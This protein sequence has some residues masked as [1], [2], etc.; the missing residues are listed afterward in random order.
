MQ[1]KKTTII[2]A[3]LSLL[4]ILSATKVN[5]GVTVNCSATKASPTCSVKFT[6]SRTDGSVITTANA[7]ET[8]GLWTTISGYNPSYHTAYYVCENSGDPVLKLLPGVANQTD[9]G[10]DWTFANAGKEKCYIVFFTMGTPP[11]SDWSNA[12]SSCQTEYVTVSGASTPTCTASFAPT[13]LTAPGSSNLTFSST[14][15]DKLSGSCTGPLPIPSVD[16]PSSYANYPFTFTATQTGTETC[17]FVP[18]NGTT[19]GTTCLASVAVSAGNN[20]PCECTNGPFSGGSSCTGGYCDGCYCVYNGSKINGL[21]GSANNQAVSSA[22]TSNL[23][24][25]GTASAVT[26]TGL[27]NWTCAGT[28]GGTTASCS[29]TKSGSGSNCGTAANSNYACSATETSGTLCVSGVTCYPNQGYPPTPCPTNIQLSGTQ[30]HWYCGTDQNCYANK[31][32]S[33]TNPAPTPSPSSDYKS[34]YQISGEPRGFKDRNLPSKA[35]NGSISIA[36]G[37]TA[38]M[39]AEYDVSLRK[40]KFFIPPGAGA[41]SNFFTTAMAYVSN[42]SSVFYA[43]RYGTPPKELTDFSD[44]YRSKLS[45]DPHSLAELMEKDCVGV[46]SVGYLEILQDSGAYADSTLGNWVYVDLYVRKGAYLSAFTNTYVNNIDSYTK[47]YNSAQWGA[48]GDPIVS[49]IIPIPALP[50]GPDCASKVCLGNSCYNGTTWIA[51]T[52][53]TDCATGSATAS[54]ASVKP[55][56]ID[57]QPVA[58]EISYLTWTSQNAKSMEVAC[59]GPTIIPRGAFFLNTAEWSTESGYKKPTTTTP[60]GYPGW[61]H[62]GAT[63]T[64]VCTFYPTNTKDSLPGTPFSA[65]IQVTGTPTCGNNI[66]EGTEECDYNPSAGAINYVPC[67]AG[68]ACKECKC[69]VNVGSVCQPDDPSCASHTCKDVSCFDGCNLQVGLKDCKGRQ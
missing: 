58:G 3:S 60:D 32:S 54:P 57:N 67:V 6:Q 29:A 42:D 7:G 10:A 23:C 8:K 49:A 51:G 13:T 40:F 62:P 36:T 15:A 43:A 69:V 21:C 68:K 25:A 37:N 48:D 47:W 31:Q 24:L 59:T 63:G 1:A 11:L 4:F 35:V 17:S 64:E 18:S 30:A 50:T 16:L 12:T 2:I 34:V 41:T 66:V 44:E 46:N 56:A 20:A 22:P 39:G 26:G 19:V 28:G 61:F 55:A 45:S 9:V 14:G 27:W 52:K 65:T 38:S 33:C 5:A 53:T